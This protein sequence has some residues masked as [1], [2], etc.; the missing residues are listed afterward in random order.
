MASV[1]CC[2]W[3][4]GRDTVGIHYDGRSFNPS[5]IIL[6]IR[7]YPFQR[8]RKNARSRTCTCMVKVTPEFLRMY[9]SLIWH[10]FCFF[11]RGKRVLPHSKKQKKCQIKDLYMHGHGIFAHVQVLD[12]AFFLF[13]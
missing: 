1:E 6:D 8:N 13:L 10:F 3:I 11:E 4:L 7:F 2:I 12:L 9:K 5:P